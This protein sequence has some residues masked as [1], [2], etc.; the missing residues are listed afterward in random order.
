MKRFF[1]LTTIFFFALQ[2]IFSQ[3]DVTKFLGIPI[4]GNKLEMR[5]KLEAK[6]FTWNS[7]LECLEG[8]FNG[9]DVYVHIVT[10]NNKVYRIFV[11][12][13]NY[14]DEV[15]IKIRFNRLCRQFENNKKYITPNTDYTIPNNE[16][17]S[18]EMRV[19]RKRYEAAFYQLPE[20]EPDTTWINEELSKYTK[21][22]LLE[23][24][25]QGNIMDV[26]SELTYAYVMDFCSKKSVWFMID[27]EGGGI[28]GRGYR[29]LM[30]YD[31]KYNEA[32]G[33]DL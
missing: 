25:A 2:M 11:A 8:E 14:R 4:D 18:Y 9:T 19:N 17:I 10:N 20:E 31:N 5:K 28:F 12:D 30:Y 21:E 22:Q 1:I 32:N 29:I 13:A 24:L 26:F 3:N 15:S 33:E 23:V 16:D 6:G 27:D 7:S